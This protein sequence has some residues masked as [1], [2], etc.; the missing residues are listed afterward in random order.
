[1]GKAYFVGIDTGTNSSKG[2]LIDEQGEILALHSTEHS[3][4]NPQ[5]GYYEHDAERDGAGC[6]CSR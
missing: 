1:M 2:A 6:L 5:P 4:E 3:M